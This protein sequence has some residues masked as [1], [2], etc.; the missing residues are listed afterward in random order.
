[1][2]VEKNKPLALITSFSVGGNAEGFV[3]ITDSN[4]LADLKE[5][6]AGDVWIIGEGANSL[7]SDHGLPGLTITMRNTGIALDGQYVTVQAGTNWDELVLFAIK[8][9]LWGIEM[10]SGIPGAVGAAVAGNIAAYGQSVADTLISV[11]VFDYKSSETRTLT[12]DE[13]DFT[14]RHSNFHESEFKSLIITSAKF[15]LSREQ[16]SELK[17]HTAKEIA[18]QTGLDPNDLNQRREIII[19]AREK[20]GSILKAESEK[21][22]G[23]FYKNPV[24]AKE[25]A[26]H[27]MTFEQRDT[28]KHHI[29]TQ[30]KIHGGDELRVSAALV[31]LAAGFNSGQTWGQVQLHPKHVLKIVNTGGATAQD[32]YNVHL[33]IT[34]TVKEKLGIEL[35][36]EV[37]FLGKF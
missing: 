22:A 7:I 18:E 35:E 5:Y 29:I 25:V 1:M 34:S 30:N 21:T 28:P 15:E 20:A 8:N 2:N 17:Y 24:V 12:K 3:E 9:N 23:S 32:I 10:T 19:K 36:P 26:E 11:E 6:F 13:L 4:Q 16:T 14:Y 31:L 33:L 37:K 27:V